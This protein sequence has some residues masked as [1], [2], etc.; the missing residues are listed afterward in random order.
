M[1]SL[2][3][4]LSGNGPGG[5]GVAPAGH[6]TNPTPDNGGVAGV[7]TIAV[8]QNRLRSTSP[9]PPGK[10]RIPDSDLTRPEAGATE[11][12]PKTQ[13]KAPATKKSESSAKTQKAKEATSKLV[14]LSKRGLSK[15]TGEPKVVAAAE[16]SK[17]EKAS[18]TAKKAG[19]PKAVPEEPKDI[20]EL[21]IVFPHDPA[22]V[23]RVDIIAIHD[24]D[25]TLQKAWVYR[26]R[27]K[28]RPNELRGVYAS[29]GINSHDGEV[30]LGTAG[31]PAPN[32]RR[33]QQPAVT[34]KKKPVDDS[35]IERWL[36]VSTRPGEEEAPQETTVETP[37]AVDCNPSPPPI[38]PLDEY[39]DSGMLPTVME[40]DDGHF[41]I[42]DDLFSRGRPGIRRRPT[43]PK[44]R[45]KSAGRINTIV[46]EQK[47]PSV[48]DVGD[49]RRY[50]VDLLSDRQ[51]SDQGLERR[52][53]WLSDFDMLPSE[54]QG[55]RVMCYTYRGIEKVPSPWQYLTER[56]ED[57]V[58]RIIQKR[59]SDSVDFGRVP[60]VLIGLGFGS[61]V[62]QR[63]VNLMAIPSRTDANPNTDLNMIAGVI[64]LD[65]P[66][67]N[68]D[69]EQFPRSRSQETKKTW[70][71]DWLGKARTTTAIQATKID[72][73][74]MWNKFCPVTSAYNISVAS[75]YAPMVLAAGKP[76]VT[77]KSLDVLLFP[78]QSMTAHRLSRFEGPN[79]ADYRSIMD[80]VKRSLI[81]RCAITESERLAVCLPDFLRDTYIVDLKDQH[82]QTAL[83]LAVKSANP[84]A[85]KR[86]LFQGRASVTRR[87]REGRSPLNI[88][89]QEAVHRTSTS[90]DPDLQKAFTQVI[91]LL[92]KNGARVDDKDNDGRSPWVY[93]EGEGNQWIRRL[94]DKYLVIGSSSTASGGMESV[95]PPK[96]GPQ[97]EASHAFD[98]ILAEVFLQKK[99][100]RF[101]EVF[102][103]DLAS[104]HEVIYKG[105]SGV[106][107]ILAASRPEQMTR[108]KV[109]CRWIHLPSNNEQW[110]HDLLLSMGI[111][112]GSMGGQRHE[113][114]R[115][116]DRYMMPQARRYKHFHGAAA[117]KAAPEPRPK[118]NRF[119]S[120]DSTATVVLGSEDFPPTPDEIRAKQASFR[121]SRA[122]PEPTRTECDAIVIFV[123][124]TFLSSSSP[125]G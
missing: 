51:S 12:G 48:G 8:P 27:A 52:V 64:L 102:N 25:E 55:A 80:A 97:R 115:L 19:V 78:K 57:L 46:E 5:P 86:L 29:G 117:K 56:A 45:K 93:A 50:N 67:P 3:A 88:A 30:G 22:S 108:D 100:E 61:L 120:T 36:A 124:A 103:F 105:T 85:V 96:P 66:S 99:R 63:A 90:G 54:I 42:S 82:G 114:S 58:R 35:A 111:Q 43:F 110:V 113:G 74:S 72:T 14:A 37:P 125:G 77:P 71:Q 16:Q 18:K 107:Q 53:N 116:I 20:T 79:D 98:M 75:H 94:K 101:S 122:V 13:G 112:D 87:D 33:P 49:A 39:D 81:I 104:V 21:R 65:A 2:T 41:Q 68:P 32:H 28:R 70:T 44:E 38:T 31:S 73:T 119:G 10:E 24:V 84:D 23:P 123:S 4:G 62:L 11:T 118:P 69:R 95:L 26:K 109:R 47:V 121:K 89:V 15:A 106:S 76:A 60:I 7:A 6:A 40:D 92:M 83:H 1:D 9:A 59:T 34:K 17:P 91:N